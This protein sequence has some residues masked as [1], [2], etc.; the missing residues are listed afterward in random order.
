MADVIEVD[1]KFVNKMLAN[2]NSENQL[3][4]INKSIK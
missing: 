3:F 2:Y 1:S 4:N